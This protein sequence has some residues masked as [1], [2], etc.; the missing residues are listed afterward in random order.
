LGRKEAL[1]EFAAACAARDAEK[2]SALARLAGRN[3]AQ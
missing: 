2:Q 1:L 3:P